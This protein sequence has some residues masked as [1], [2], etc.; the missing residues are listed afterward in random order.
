MKFNEL[1]EGYYFIRGISNKVYVEKLESP[2]TQPRYVLELETI[3]IVR[4]GRSYK[5]NGEIL[6]K[7]EVE[8]KTYEEMKKDKKSRGASYGHVKRRLL[9]NEPLTGKTLELAL[10]LVETPPNTG[11]LPKLSK[12]ISH[13]LQNGQ[14]LDE[15]ELHVMVDVLLLHAR[16]G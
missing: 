5:K 14:P 1:P 6:D 10:E 16:L 2:E 11:D 8:F 12:S 4:D 7:M 15:Y 3:R 9:K 13:K